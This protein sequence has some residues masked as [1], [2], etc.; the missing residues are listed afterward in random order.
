MTNAAIPV[1]VR[2]RLSGFW[3]ADIVYE[4]R[5]DPVAVLSCLCLLTLVVSALLANL[6][7]PQNPFDLRQLD[8]ADSML[9]PAW[10]AEGSMRYLLG[11]DDQGRDMLSAI[12]YGTRI[13][14]MV[15][16]LSVALSIVLGV[17]LGLVSGLVGGWFDALL[18][19]IADVQLS[20]PAI[21]IAMLIDGAARAALPGQLHDQVAVPILVIAISLSGWVQYARTVRGATLVEKTKEYVLAAEVIGVPP[22]R[23]MLRHILPNVSGPVFVLATVHI[24]TAI[25]TEATLSFLGVGVPPTAPSLGSLI[26]IGNDYLFSGDWWITVFP[27]CALICLVLS[28]NLLG[29]W[30][31]DAL[32]PRLK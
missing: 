4:F 15:G 11:T 20:F 1:A 17:I 14:L 7:A 19:R 16:F 2:S 31:R 3:D 26:R 23:I 6:I 25:L 18:M 12:L 24:A 32:N 27:G 5:H 9:P 22:R 10:S 30:L 29:D 13:S 21:L 28:A 8:I